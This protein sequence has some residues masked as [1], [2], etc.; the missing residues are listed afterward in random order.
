MFDKFIK[1]RKVI[2]M[3]EVLF[4]DFVKK[5]K[6][7]FIKEAEIRGTRGTRNDIEQ[8]YMRNTAKH[9]KALEEYWAE[10]WTKTAEIGLHADKKYI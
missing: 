5:L 9:L 1:T 7:F 6:D 2:C 3:V 8:A 4:K 10:N